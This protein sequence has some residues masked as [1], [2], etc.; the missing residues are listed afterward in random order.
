MP[1]E[2]VKFV[3]IVPA[4]YKERLLKVFM[5]LGLVHL[6]P[7]VSEVSLPVPA[8]ADERLEELEGLCKSFQELRESLGKAENLLADI[9]SLKVAEI[10]LKNENLNILKEIGLPEKSIDTLEKIIEEYDKLRESRPS[11]ELKI[12]I[13][14]MR[15][16]HLAR[17]IV[18]H[19]R[20]YLKDYN[21]VFEILKL[22]DAS[23]ILEKL[24]DLKREADELGKEFPEKLDIE[25][26]KK[27]AE[28]GNKAL[29]LLNNLS[30]NVEK[31]KEK[32]I[33]R[34]ITSNYDAVIKGLK[35]YV[36]LASSILPYESL[37]E[38]LLKVHNLVKDFD[39]VRRVR[40]SIAEGWI[41]SRYIENFKELLESTVPRVL[42]MRIRKALKGEP[43]PRLIQLKGF[44]GQIAKIT[45]MRGVPSYWEIDPTLIFTA[46]FTTMYGMMFGDIG[47]GAIIAVFGIL[48]RRAKEGFLGMSK[49]G[50][51]ALSTLSLLCGVSAIIFGALYGVSFLV[52]IWKPILL[53]P[54]HNLNE[55]IG[56]ALLF[57]A[58]QL[59]LSMILNIVNCIKM[60]EFF[61][62]IFGARGVA[63][64]IFYISGVY[65]A[66]NIVISGFNLGVAASSSLLPFTAVVI[67]VM[68][69]IPLTFILK[70][71]MTKHSEYMIHGV[72]EIL[73][74]IIEYPANSL[75]YIRLAAFALAHEAFGI[76]AE[77]LAEFLGY[78]PSII[79][80]NVLVLMIEGFAVGIQALRLT[81]Y[82]FSTKFFKGEGIL[83]EPITVPVSTKTS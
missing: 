75:S 72:I 33:A 43:V 50:I 20:K 9:V 23:E 64:L 6:N 46:L 77:A 45:L 36:K 32:V 54:L 15:R 51:K 12:L 25:E 65:I 2:M 17:E 69:L 56:M 14:E 59:I 39:V 52:E 35:E 49:A 28:K 27:M 26:L 34:R 13:D 37:A 60:R 68:L 18:E 71:I 62:A 80:S 66:Y 22:K 7:Q 79:F 40:V 81:Y 16:T 82:E 30:I 41:P 61:E 44:R 38:L 29:A 67:G 3:V 24:E 42:Y 76:L 31:A 58:L 19:V 21:K 83:F 5:K 1:E 47:L 74:L 63:G 10:V 57:G 70:G 4:E 78:A 55:I 48:I 73:E 8:L 53:S 11:D